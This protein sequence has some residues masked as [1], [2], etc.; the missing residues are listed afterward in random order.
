MNLKA[1]SGSVSRTLRSIAAGGTRCLT[2][3]TSKLGDQDRGRAGDEEYE[4]GYFAS[5]FA[6]STPQVRELTAKP[7][8]DRVTLE[9]E[10][11]AVRGQ[12]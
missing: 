7:G 2:T 4:V 11:K 5:K 3:R 12:R 9:R 6:L 1:R 10:A 8:N